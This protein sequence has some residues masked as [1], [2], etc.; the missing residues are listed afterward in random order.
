M[1]T[2]DLR[3]DPG[4]KPRSVTSQLNII[5]QKLGNLYQRTFRRRNHNCC[6]KLKMARSCEDLQKRL[7]DRSSIPTRVSSSHAVI[8]E[9]IHVAIHTVIHEV[10]HLAIHAV[11]HAAIQAVIH[12]AI[13]A[14]IY[15]DV[16]EVIHV[17]MPTVV[18]DAWRYATRRF[19]PAR[20]P[21]CAPH[22]LFVADSRP[23][24]SS[25]L[26]WHDG[27]G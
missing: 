11:I 17:A 9:V 19:P 7:S 13:H 21:T 3:V 8:Y 5:G 26:R 15:K 1:G 27:Y 12:V 25:A 22:P 4:G 18:H 24:Q 6:R 16:H 10:I 23:P 14:L 2:V 20:L